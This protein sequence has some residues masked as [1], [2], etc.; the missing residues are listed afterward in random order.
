MRANG[1]NETEPW[2]VDCGSHNARY[3]NPNGRLPFKVC[4]PL[5]ADIELGDVSPLAHWALYAP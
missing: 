1:V 3:V 5:S 4:H 2:R